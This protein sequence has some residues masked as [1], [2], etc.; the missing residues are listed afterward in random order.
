M[1]GTLS[2]HA[3]EVSAEELAR[4][5]RGVA[6]AERELASLRA[7]L[8]TLQNR[9]LAEIGVL[10]SDLGRLEA[11]LRDAEIRAGLRLP[12]DIDTE[13][14]DDADAGATASAGCV[15]PAAPSDDLKRVFRDVAKAVHPDLA[16]DEMARCRRHSLMAEANRA[17]AERDADRL[18]LILQAFEQDVETL[19]DDADWRIR[20]VRRA[21]RLR[22]RLTHLQHERSALE[23]SAIARLERKIAEARAQ[24]WDLW[25]EMLQQV[26]RDISTTAAR[27]AKLRL[28]RT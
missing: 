19:P 11:E 23:G 15:N 16:L 4:L 26:R 12:E 18:R 27:I 3:G 8:L 14:T 6:D 10:Y 9:Y 28:L 1:S 20:S 2:L 25:A 5:E 17:Y 22:D 21:A 7:E 13:D 24:G